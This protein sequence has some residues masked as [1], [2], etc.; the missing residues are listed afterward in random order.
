MRPSPPSKKNHN[1]QP[2][3]APALRPSHPSEGND[4][5]QPYKRGST[6]QSDYKLEEN[7]QR[8]KRPKYERRS[9][10]EENIR[11][12]SGYEITLGDDDTRTIDRYVG[13]GTRRKTIRRGGRQERDKKRQREDEES[14]GEKSTLIGG[15]YL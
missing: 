6:E 10:I 7:I 9:R 1:A 5:A 15:S 8:R 3:H 12:Q 2:N 4:Y 13:T 11:D 14:S